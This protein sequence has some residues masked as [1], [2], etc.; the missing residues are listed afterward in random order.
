MRTFFGALVLAPLLVL[1]VGCS[2]G[3]TSEESRQVTIPPS[4]TKPSPAAPASP[5]QGNT[6]C[7]E[8]VAGIDDFNAGDFEGTVAHF[9]AAVPLAE[10]EA[11]ANPG[12]AADDLLEAVRYYADLAPDDY[13]QA[14][15]SSSEFAKYKAITLE[16]CASGGSPQDDDGGAV[17]A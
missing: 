10:N 9:E 14:S 2:E 13:T 16:Q 12:Q 4:D 17:F 8:V 1:G 7:D 11:E 5:D 6:A 3:G 15:V